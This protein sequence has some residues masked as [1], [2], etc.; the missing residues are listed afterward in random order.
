MIGAI[1][2]SQLSKEI[3]WRGLIICLVDI[4]SAQGMESRWCARSILVPNLD[5][6]K[7]RG[8]TRNKMSVKYY[9]GWAATGHR[10]EALY[11]AKRSKS[12][13]DHD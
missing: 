11:R 3:A 9:T 5:A 8:I 4:Q 10:R 12:S 13:I 6:S 7:C 1:I 2:A